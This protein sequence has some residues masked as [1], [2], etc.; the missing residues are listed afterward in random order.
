MSPEE[1]VFDAKTGLLVQVVFE[2]KKV[3]FADYRNVDG[4]MVPFRQNVD[5]RSPDMPE[6]ET[7]IRS[8][9]FNVRLDD[10][11]FEAPVDAADR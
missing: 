4:V 8:I 10:S 9:E 3:E 6:Y 1:L 11:L 7:S 5:V 2:Y